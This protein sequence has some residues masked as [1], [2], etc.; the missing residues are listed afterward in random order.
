MVWIK[1]WSGSEID[2]VQQID[3]GQKMI[4]IKRLI[5]IK[6]WYGWEMLLIWIKN[7]SRSK[8]DINPKLILIPLGY[9]KFIQITNWSRS[10]SG[11]DKNWSGSKI[12][13]DPKLIRI[14]NWSGSKIDL[15]PKLIWIQNWSHFWV[16][17]IKTKSRSKMI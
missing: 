11:L 14:Q 17:W 2:Q 5:W 6:N 16:I 9:Q 8:N 1:N 10:K 12:D 7:K 15:D 3:L 13:L 4:W